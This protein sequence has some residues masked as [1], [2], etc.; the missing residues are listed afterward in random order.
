MKKIILQ[1]IAVSIMLTCSEKPKI[2]Y[3]DI[4]NMITKEIDENNIPGAVVLIGNENEIIFQK[5]YGVKNPKTNEKYNYDDIFRIASMTKAITSFGVVKLWEKGLIE[6]DDPIKKYIP[7]FNYVEILNSFNEDDTTYTTIERT[8]DIT[9]RQLLTH[10][11]GIGYD[12]IDGNP[13]IKAVYH[14]KKQNFM[15]NGVLCF[16]DQDVTIGESITKLATVP[17]HHEPGEK[18]TYG[19]GLDVL[20]YMIEIVSKKSLDVFFKEEIFEP[21]EM[22]DTYFYL[23]EDKFER[24]VPV[25]SFDSGLSYNSNSS[26]I[27]SNSWIIFEDDRF[28]VNYPI[29]G[30]RVFFAGG[31]GLSSTVRDYYNFLSIFINNGKFKGKQIIKK[32]TNDMVFENQ[33]SDNF[34]TSIGLVFG[35]TSKNDEWFNKSKTEGILHWGGYWNTSFFADDKNK[36]I[37]LIYKQTQNTNETSWDKLREIIY[38]S[39]D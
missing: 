10:T 35:I 27:E 3:N 5:S 39:I 31:C 38:N 19:I 16:C 30:E 20:G 37:A 7:E 15:D 22:N 1:I 33:L 26:N 18:F 25:Q 36:L 17:L 21:L 2:N 13:A 12:F 24:L 32:S 29:E 11:S 4:D 23:P 14:K 9:I 8:K 28:N 6:F 34:N